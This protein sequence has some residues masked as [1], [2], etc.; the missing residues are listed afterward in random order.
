MR[1]KHEAEEVM[2]CDNNAL[3]IKIVRENGNVTDS[4]L[5]EQEIKLITPH[6]VILNNGTK[7]QL[8]EKINEILSQI[9]PS[10]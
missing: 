1:F 3:I 10:S 8:Y 9:L 6:H 2:K 5:S 7:D 4:H